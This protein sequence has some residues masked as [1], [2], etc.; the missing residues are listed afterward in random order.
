MWIRSSLV[1]HGEADL[2]ITTGLDVQW[3]ISPGKEY[4]EI[5]NHKESAPSFWYF[6]TNQLDL[7]IGLDTVSVIRFWKST[8][9]DGPFLFRPVIMY[10]KNEFN[11]S[12]VIQYD[13]NCIT[14]KE[15]YVAALISC[16]LKTFT[17]HD[18]GF[19][20]FLLRSVLNKSCVVDYVR[21]NM[22]SLS[23][24]LNINNVKNQ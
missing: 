9:F 7:F 2:L 22:L 24:S 5:N 4:P 17:A 19:W 10:L 6:K 11:L 3:F 14:L 12:Y 16:N 8:S 18:F 15:I 21:L 13:F 20:H 23:L 1:V